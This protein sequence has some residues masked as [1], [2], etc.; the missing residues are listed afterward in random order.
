MCWDLLLS[1]V[2]LLQCHDDHLHWH[3]GEQ[4][5]GTVM[6]IKVIIRSV[7]LCNQVHW[8]TRGWPTQP[9]NQLIYTWSTHYS[10][11]HV[12]WDLFLSQETVSQCH[13]NHLHGH[14]GKTSAG[15]VIVFKMSMY[16]VLHMITNITFMTNRN[17]HTNKYIYRYIHISRSLWGSKARM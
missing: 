14:I 4:S 7:W 17:Q 9:V 6:N 1:Q 10:P 8:S 12:C 11:C 5:F 13:D 3:S 15:T 16:I 2:T